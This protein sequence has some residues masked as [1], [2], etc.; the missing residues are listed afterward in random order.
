MF[1]GLSAVWFRKGD[2]RGESNGVFDKSLGGVQFPFR[3]AEF[4][5]HNRDLIPGGS[6]TSRGIEEV[7]PAP[8]E[9][10]GGHALSPGGNGFGKMSPWDWSNQV[11]KIKGRYR[12]RGDNP[13]I[14]RGWGGKER[15]GNRADGTSGGGLL[16]RK[17]PPT[18]P[19]SPPA[20][21]GDPGRETTSFSGG[22]KL[23]KSPSFCTMEAER[24]EGVEA[25]LR[26]LS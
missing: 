23:G 8:V 4:S 9:D 1:A 6:E 13:S 22:L 7:G 14:L 5:R 24:S 12:G 10:D 26:R 11:S 20:A 21:V 19:L 16:V 17:L 2:S 3:T 15:P 18:P 25:H